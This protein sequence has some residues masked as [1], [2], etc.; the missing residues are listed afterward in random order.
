MHGADLV[1]SKR[2]AEEVDR[3][4]LTAE[5][6]LLIQLGRCAD[7]ALVERLEIMRMVNY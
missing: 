4:H 7:V 5:H 3:G 1:C 2:L 6:P